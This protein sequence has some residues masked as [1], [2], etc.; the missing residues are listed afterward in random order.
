MRKG[1]VQSERNILTGPAP[2]YRVDSVPTNVMLWLV[3]AAAF[4]SLLPLWLHYDIIS[5][6]GAF[7]YIPTARFFLEGCF[8]DGFARPQ[9]LFPLLIAGVSWATGAS[10]E[11]AG[12]LISACAFII[13]ALGMFKLGELIFHDRWTALVSV[14]FLITNRELAEDSVDCLKESLLVACILWGNFFVLKGLE[15]ET[16][17]RKTALFLA[18]LLF[19]LGM[20]IRSTALFFLGAWLLIWVFNR[21]GGRALRT[22]LLVV[23]AVL[24]VILWF[25]N[26]DLPLYKKSYNLGLIF[27]NPHTIPGI[28]QS[29]G[30]T[31]VELFSTGNLL[32]V[33]A[34]CAAFFFRK[35]DRYTTHLWLSALIFLV[36][37]T[38]WGFT[39][40]RYLLALIAWIYPLAAHAVIMMARSTSRP[41]RMASFLVVL[42]ACAFWAD[43]AMEGPDPNKLAR[44]EAGLYILEHAGPDRSIITNR[45]RLAFYAGGT[46]VPLKKAS[47]VKK[48]TG[49][50]AID[51][52]KEGG[53]AGRTYM[54]GI[55][56][57]PARVFDT[58]HVYLPDSI[59]GIPAQ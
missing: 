23:P 39:S 14:L 24:F 12:R 11:L 56:K 34:G 50:L 20:F 22:A 26:P 52:E 40:G 19:L 17:R 41:G 42:A 27:N 59:E 13:A 35:K 44:K 7:Q 28:L 30:N 48:S 37:L 18:G 36:V 32:V 4:L 9:P 6:D 8:L 43:K 47:D 55:G 10:P 21:K 31:V 38:A 54:E 45:D 3:S 2:R 1:A 51:V 16:E 49:I 5:P 15:E 33:S 58:I 25:V 46:Y 57:S 29:A 53:E